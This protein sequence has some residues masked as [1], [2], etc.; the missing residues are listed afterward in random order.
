VVAAHPGDAK[1]LVR[2]AHLGAARVRQ[3]PGAVDQGGTAQVRSVLV[4][5]HLGPIYQSAMKCLFTSYIHSSLQ[6]TENNFEIST[7][8]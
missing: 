5:V 2:V 1:L 8:M 4:N 6:I 7:C 3:Q